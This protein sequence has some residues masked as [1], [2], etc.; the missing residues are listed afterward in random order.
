MRW[1]RSFVQTGVGGVLSGSVMAGCGVV[2]RI[3]ERLWR[4]QY[5]EWQ[6]GHWTGTLPEFLRVFQKWSQRLHVRMTGMSEI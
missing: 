1:Q 4:I 5:G 3:L 6:L 2:G